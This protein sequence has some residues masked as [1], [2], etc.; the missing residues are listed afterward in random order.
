ML[1]RRLFYGTLIVATLLILS[2]LDVVISHY[3]AKREIFWLP[4]GIVLLPVYLA[5]LVFLTREVLRILDAAGLHPLD[6]TVYLGNL[7]IAA[8]CWLANVYQQYRLD[9]LEEGLSKGGWRWASAASFCALLAIAGGVILAFA[10]EMRRYS[11]PGGVTI[12]LAGAV[13]AT[14]YLGT[15]SCFTIQLHM[16]YEIW[17]ILSLVIVTKMCDI[18]AFTIGKLF[19][20]H[21]MTPGLS[22][23][24]TIEGAIGG[25]A[26]ACFGAWFWFALILPK[27]TDAQPT[28]WLGWLSFGIVIALMGMVGDLGGSLIKRDSHMKDSGHSIPGFG[29]VLD[30]FDSL[31]MAAPAAYFFWAFGFVCPGKHL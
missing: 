30:V 19:G 3:G 31:L 17:A 8:S 26:F 2:W 12:N 14:A 28:P 20:R 9:V 7:L 29:G 23:G 13:F 16:A 24:K 21:K 4:R 6:S 22:P 27:F 10:A 18:G 25:I 5:C 11:Q 1:Q 15:L